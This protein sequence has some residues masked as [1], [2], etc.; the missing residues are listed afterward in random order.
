[1]ASTP[2]RVTSSHD[3]FVQFYEKDDFLVDEVSGFIGAG[4][5][6][7]QAGIVIATQPH[8]EA[9]ERRLSARLLLA[10]D[11]YIAL[12]ASATLSQLMVDGWPDE[13]RFA[14]VI[15][16]VIRQ[17]AQN[18][19][20]S[21]CAFGEMVALL[22]AEGRHAAA[23]R[24]E[25]LWNDLAR[26]QSFSLLCAYPMAGFRDEEHANPFLEICNAHSRVRPAESFVE[27]AG[28]AEVR[29]QVAHLQQRAA[30]LETEVA[31]RKQTERAL[32]L[33]EQELADFL[34]NAVEGLHQVGP[35]GRILWANRAEL[36]MLGYDR[37]QY[38]G[39]HIAEFHVDRE[40]VADMLDKLQHG[41]ALY[42][43]PARLRCKN[44]SIKHVQVHSN[45]LFE[46]GE[47]I[48][49]RCFT[50]DTTD[51]VRLEMELQQRLEQLAEQ[52]RRKTEFLAMLGHELRNPL[53]V[54]MNGAELMRLKS[55]DPV[56]A[57]RLS[58]R[59]ARQAAMMSRLID[60]LLDVSRI[61]RGKIELKPETVLL[62]TLV[63]RAVEL[64]RPLVGE[65]G[66]RLTIDLPAEPVSLFGDAARLVQVLCNLLQ[67]AAKY[68]DPG[69]NIAL[70]ARADGTDLLLSVRDDGLGMTAELCEQVFE[71][72]VQ[73]P[74]SSEHARGGLGVG[75]A[76]VRALVDQHG[77]SVSAASDGPG[78]GSEFVVRL[79][80]RQAC[81][82]P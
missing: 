69:G 13:G 47:L 81:S 45:A 11:R 82:T 76:L 32:R 37:E 1:M 52:D 66:H 77:G 16:G 25:E 60:D 51:R 79:P 55:D 2:L 4:L 59:V 38:V 33:R 18:G 64:V 75:L 29:C 67:N 46:Q 8:R 30:A 36:D 9:L 41:E 26:T 14:E 24:L 65:R 39:H 44:G 40:V 17:A 43:Y 6:A 28:P 80:L 74:S 68:T 23:I 35:D 20:R 19:S 56:Q 10:A 5:E 15:G 57:A 27:T 78:R 62:G 54:I 63:E 71:P 61:T 3:H 21:V 48:H 50:R 72:F 12:D 31:K 70:H 53:A 42:D 73:A 22:W 7:G 58:E 34:E 49:T